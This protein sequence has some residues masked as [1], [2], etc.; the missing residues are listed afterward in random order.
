MKS[1]RRDS[2]PRQPAWKASFYRNRF[3]KVEAALQAPSAVPSFIEAHLTKV[4]TTLFFMTN[5]LS[6]SMTACPAI[7]FSAKVFASSHRQVVSHWNCFLSYYNVFS[8]KKQERQVFACS[9]FYDAILFCIAPTDTALF[10]KAPLTI[11]IISF[12]WVVERRVRLAILR[13]VA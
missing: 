2:N 10:P 7:T 13:Q 8:A 3:R 12:L 4:L 5:C 9:S 6:Q 1:G 11:S